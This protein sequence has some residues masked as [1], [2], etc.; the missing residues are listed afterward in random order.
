MG[1]GYLAV[2][3]LKKPHGLKGEVVVWTLT[4]DPE[5]VLATGRELVPVDERGEPIGP[6]AVIERSRPYQRQ[7]L[8]KFEG[9]ADRTVLEGWGQ[10]LF[11]APRSALVPPGR[12]ELYVHEVP[13]ITV[14]ADGAVV[15]RAVDIL[16]IPGGRVLVVD[17]NGREVLVPFRAPIVRR[18][19]R[20]RRTIE[21]DPPPGLLEL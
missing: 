13:G 15:G 19:D 10:R 2:A 7:W 17:V 18:I 4:D 3:R 9:V 11:G 12:D 8:L 20:E 14:V 6:P 1:G 16:D 21:I 5:H